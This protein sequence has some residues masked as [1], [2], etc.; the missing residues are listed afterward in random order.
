ML[1]VGIGPG[2]EVIMPSF[3]FVSAANAVVLRG[4][5]PI[6]AEIQSATLNLDPD[7]VARRITD[8]T[9]VVM[10]VHYAGIGCDMDA[11]CE[12]ARDADCYVVEDAA[13]AI[14]A[15]YKGQ[16]LG[17][18]GDIGA[19]SFH[20]TKNIICGEG[21]AFVTS[22]EAL[23]RR[24]EIIVEKGTNRAA[25]FRGE[26]D[27]YTWVSPGS[28]YIPSD[29]LVAMLEVQLAKRAEI[30][31][32]RKQVWDAYITALRPLAADGWI[33]LPTVPN[34]CESNY[35][36]FFFHVKTPEMRNECLQHLC[37]AG[38]QAAFHYV[39][40]HSS[41]FGRRTLQ[42][43]QEL[44]ITDRCSQTLIRLPLYPHLADRLADLTERVTSSLVES[45][46]SF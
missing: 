33:E 18:I 27:K 4:A 42:N 38:I 30:K 12:I 20:D 44:P 40:L 35:H 9:K 46:A 24:A 23:A 21:G 15:K 1:V 37:G 41:P 6:F 39:P 34:E 11:I 25:F 13:Q 5:T 29:L 26:V 43:D 32:K 2:D 19:Y 3:T 36:T 7:D 45:L 17:T 10:P 31:A 8:H 28:S 14:D 16:F 22:D